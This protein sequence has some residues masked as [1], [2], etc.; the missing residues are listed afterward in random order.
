MSSQTA[1]EL[2]P[3]L[4]LDFQPKPETLRLLSA[5]ILEPIDPT[6]PD[7]DLRVDPQVYSHDV[8]V[9]AFAVA[10]LQVVCDITGVKARGNQMQMRMIRQFFV[11]PDR[12]SETYHEP[13]KG[14]EDPGRDRT[15]QRQHALGQTTMRGVMF[16]AQRRV[17][18]GEP[19]NTLG[20]AVYSQLAHH[21]YIQS[22]WRLYPL[23]LEAQQL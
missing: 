12:I 9:G 5:P 22:V 17:D 15:L 4:Y 1:T 14:E 23:F 20:Q 6:D 19:Y 2:L 3:P 7:A 10:V 13:K 16:E 11:D 21:G 8:H 18:R